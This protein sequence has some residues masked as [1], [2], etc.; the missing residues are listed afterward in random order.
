MVEEGISSEK[1]NEEGLGISDKELYYLRR[2]Q[3]KDDDLTARLKASGRGWKSQRRN[4]LVGLGG[5]RG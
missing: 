4:G 1:Y 3:H 5:R 2:G